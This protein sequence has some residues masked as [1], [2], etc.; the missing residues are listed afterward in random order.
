MLFYEYHF[1]KSNDL[2]VLIVSYCSITMVL[3]AESSF[4]GQEDFQSL[5]TSHEEATFPP[6]YIAVIARL[7]CLLGS[8]DG[9]SGK[10][11]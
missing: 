9:A 1:N 10:F 6:C 8:A 11:V 2:Q 3:E 4:S 5:G 7:V